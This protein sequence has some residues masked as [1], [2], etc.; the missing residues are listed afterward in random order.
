[1][2]QQVDFSGVEHLNQ[3]SSGATPT[4]TILGTSGPDSF[5]YTPTDTTGGTVNGVG[6]TINFTGVASTFTLDAGAGTDT[7]TVNGT[8]AADTISVVK[9][10]TTT[11]K[12]NGL[13]T[14]SLPAASDEDVTIAAGD[15]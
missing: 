7:V 12:V 13:Q 9:G 2:A 1:G 4:L 3:T 14:V 11:V 8:S 15:G 6:P 10:A 5:T